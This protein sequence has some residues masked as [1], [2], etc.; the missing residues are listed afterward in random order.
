MSL[1]LKHIHNIHTD[2]SY[3][4][5]YNYNNYDSIIYNTTTIYEIKYKNISIKINRNVASDIIE[6]DN[7]KKYSTQQ[8]VL[9]VIGN[10]Q[11]ILYDQKKLI[12]DY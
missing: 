10:E 7:N 4:L 11:Y 5:P 8:F 6:K 12:I 1:H 2:L 9:K 3:S